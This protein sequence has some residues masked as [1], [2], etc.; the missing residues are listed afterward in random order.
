MKT[1]AQIIATM[2]SGN[3]E[4]IIAEAVRGVIDWVDLFL[5]IDTGITDKTLEIIRE[6]AGAKFRCDSFPW[7]KDFAQARNFALERAAKHGAVWALTVDTD[8]RLSFA[9]MNSLE[10]LRARLQADPEVLV[11]LVSYEGGYYAKERIIRVP[12]QL[13]WQG[14]THEALVGAAASQRGILAGASFTELPKNPEQVAAK[15]KRDLEI[16]RDETQRLP[17]DPRWWYYLG[18]TLEDLGERREAVEA[19]RQCSVLEGWVEQAAWA[20]Y[21]GA[22]CLCHLQEFQKAIEL[23]AFGL[24]KQ[25]NSPELAWLAGL[26][27]YNLGQDANAICW[28]QMAVALG[29]FKG[30]HSGTNRTGFRHVIS[31]YEGPYDVMR[32]AYRRLGL[33]QAVEIAEKEYRNALRMREEQ[34]GIR[35]T[36]NV[37]ESRAA[38]EC[39][40]SRE[41]LFDLGSQ[42][43]E[44]LREH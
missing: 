8:E 42:H 1:N 9:G 40:D 41:F 2:L 4:A 13:S 29:H 39:A 44:W 16:L 11:W 14:R 23:C 35:R 22:V 21:K 34:A 28:E 30:I 5:L 31:W 18:Q 7:C 19:Y 36:E 15:L 6:L 38:S 33:Q 25:P 26:A 12:S 10:D 3:S 27:C 24:S 37:G 32:F 17:H 20:C 43:G